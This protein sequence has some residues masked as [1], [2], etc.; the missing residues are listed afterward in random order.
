MPKYPLEPLA[1][2]RARRAEAAALELA[3]AIRDR[4]AAARTLRVA[5]LRRDGHAR[6]VS[7]V[8]GA[9]R[10]ALGRGELCA[11]D[12]ARADAWG[13]RAAL[14]RQLLAGA[15]GR[16]ETAA[17]SASAHEREAQEAVAS[18]RADAHVVAGHRAR[19]NEGERRRVEAREEE[20]SSEAW[21]PKH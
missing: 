2:L 6:V 17:A 7:A 3:G 1:A 18:R 8:R 12:L 9:E 4:E 5:E 19:W 21:R 11:R 20:A 13:I 16:A 15:V 14:E 10:D